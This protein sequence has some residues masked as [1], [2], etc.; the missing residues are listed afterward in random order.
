MDMPFARLPLRVLTNKELSAWARL[1]YPL[2]LNY[3]S[4]EHGCFPGQERL[5]ADLGVSVDTIGRA[6]NELVTARLIAKKR[7]GRGHTNA[8]V[9]LL[10]SAPTR[11]QEYDSA[12]TRIPDSAPVRTVESAPVRN[13]LYPV[14]KD[15]GK[16]GDTPL[17][18]QGGER[19]KPSTQFE[20]FWAEYPK[21]HGSKQQ[22]WLQWQKIKPDDN[23]LAEILGGL[24]AWKNCGRWQRGYVK[25]AQT[26]L[27]YRMWAD[28]PPVDATPR[29]GPNGTYRGKDIGLSND[30]LEAIARGER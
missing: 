20:Q 25:E 6:L 28:D 12:P 15:L 4:E 1:L 21:G 9:L 3:H 10:D 7:R 11:N 24:D 16:E 26:W 8:Y 30:E 19:G 5:A 17:T 22:S 13:N 2:L 18:P 23:L 14:E 27:K 29:A